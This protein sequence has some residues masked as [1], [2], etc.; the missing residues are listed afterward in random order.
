MNKLKL[1]LIAFSLLIFAALSFNNVQAADFSWKAASSVSATPTQ[2]GAAMWR[3]SEANF[4]GAASCIAPIGTYSNGV[5]NFGV[6]EICG[7]VG[8][9][10]STG[11]NGKLSLPLTLGLSFN[12]GPL[13][14]HVGMGPD[15]VGTPVT[16]GAVTYPF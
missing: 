14:A 1:S 6:G 10:I 8:G 3:N 9:A 13:S 7:S 5:L 12:E 16:M 2:I 15:I 11:A 4:T